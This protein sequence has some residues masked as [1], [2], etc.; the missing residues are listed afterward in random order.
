MHPLEKATYQLIVR[1]ELL[2]PAESV[3]VGCSAGPDSMALLHVLG[4]L[5][6]RLSVKPVAV[7]V[8]HGLRPGETGRERELVESRAAVLDITCQSFRVDAAREAE[9]KKLSLEHA[10][11]NLRYGILEQ[12][13]SEY[14]P[15]RIAVAHTADDQAEEVLLR[16]IRGTGRAGLAGMKMIRDKRIIRPFL[17]R[18]KAELLSYLKRYDIPWLEDSS[19]LET[20]FLRNRL[21]L[22]VIPELAGI[23]PNIS[24]T[25]R[26]TAEVLQD[27]ELVLSRLTED[28]WRELVFA[29]PEAGKV[30]ID[31]PGF[32]D[33]ERA[34]RRRLLEKV[35]IEMSARPQGEK[36]EQILYLAETG[37]TGA[38][39]HFSG[40]LRLKKARGRLLFSYPAGRISARGNLES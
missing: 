32:R 31:L 40:G 37:E 4:A 9:E 17:T 15:A 30:S 39:L 25:L 38:R 10:A 12:L 29:E 1:E 22:E 28:A 6:P 11:R 26:R 33:L 8:D 3:I 13:A 2:A 34:I 19:N 14:E 21:R 35:F 36:I 16:L 24:E 5:G 27:E 18:T 23:N 20:R 7:Y